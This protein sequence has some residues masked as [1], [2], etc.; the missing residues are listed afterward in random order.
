MI[1]IYDSKITDILPDYIKTD[2]EVQAIGFS[3]SNQIKKIKDKVKIVQL[4]HS[5]DILPENILDILAVELRTQ[6][7]DEMLEVDIKSNLIKNS[8]ALYLC[9]GTPAAVEEVIS[10]LFGEGVVKEWF[11]Y[12]GEPYNFYLDIKPT[13]PITEDKIKQIDKMISNVKNCRSWMEYIKFKI[14]ENHKSYLKTACMQVTYT[15]NVLSC[16]FSKKDNLKADIKS[17]GLEISSTY[18]KLI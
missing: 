12:E 11:D 16:D 7:Y 5:I 15:H 10:I 9:S 14:H 3:I 6:Y 13:K 4:F 1:N 8:L 18:N 2:C 17:S